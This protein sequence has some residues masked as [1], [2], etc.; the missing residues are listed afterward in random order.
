[1]PNKVNMIKIKVDNLINIVQEIKS[2]HDKS[3]LEIRK[4][5]D[6]K[7]HQNSKKLSEKQIAKQQK[8][9][10]KVDNQLSKL[11][12]L[13]SNFAATTRAYEYFKKDSE[14]FIEYIS[15]KEDADVNDIFV[16]HLYT[17]YKDNYAAILQLIMMCANR[18]LSINTNIYKLVTEKPKLNTFNNEYNVTIK[19]VDDI[20]LLYNYDMKS[21]TR[22]E[23]YIFNCY[24]RNIQSTG[25]MYL[26]LHPICHGDNIYFDDNRYAIIDNVCRDI[27]RKY[28]NSYSSHSNSQPNLPNIEKKIIEDTINV[29]LKKNKLVPYPEDDRFLTLSRYHRMELFVIKKL[30]ELYNDRSNL[31]LGL[32]EEYNLDKDQE[33]FLDIMG[34][35]KLSIL[36]GYPGTGK[37]HVISEI[38][39]NIRTRYKVII[40]APTGIAVCNINNRLSVYTSINE[41]IQQVK[42]NKT[43]IIGNTLSDKEKM[44]RYTIKPLTIHR[45]INKINNTR[46]KKKDDI[47]EYMGDVP[48]NTSG[49]DLS[50]I[51]GYIN[52]NII[53]CMANGI[54]LK[55][56]Q[57]TL[58]EF[59]CEDNELIIII[60]ECSMVNLDVTYG[61]FKALDNHVYGDNYHL[62]LVG[63][64]NQLPPIGIGNFFA[65]ILES[66]K[67]GVG[68]KGVQTGG[69]VQMGCHLHLTKIHRITDSTN[70]S[71]NK[72]KMVSKNLINGILPPKGEYSDSFYYNP[73][74]F[75]DIDELFSDLEEYLPDDMYRGSDLKDILILCATNYTRRILNSKIQSKIYREDGS[76]FRYNQVNFHMDEKIIQLE[77]N[78]DK[79]VFNGE[80]GY[81]KQ[82]KVDSAEKLGKKFI[83]IDFSS[84]KSQIKLREYYKNFSQFDIGYVLTTHKS[85]GIE[86]DTVIII[87]ENFY[88][89]NR[90]LI[91]TAITRAKKKVIMLIYDTSKSSDSY[92]LNMLDNKMLAKVEIGKTIMKLVNCP[93]C[94]GLV[95][96]DEI[97]NLKM[98]KQCFL[99]KN[100]KDTNDKEYDYDLKLKKW[101]VSNK[102]IKCGKCN[103]SKWC[104]DLYPEN[105]DEHKEMLSYSG[106]LAASVRTS[107]PGAS[108]GTGL[109]CLSCYC[110]KYK[111]KRKCYKCTDKMEHVNYGYQTFKGA[112]MCSGCYGSKPYNWFTKGKIKCKECMYMSWVDIKE[113]KTNKK[114]HGK[115]YWC[116]KK[117]ENNSQ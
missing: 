64:Q 47:Q 4:L 84:R 17:K 102:K 34:N 56:I 26:L 52:R 33:Q 72:I 101:V 46:L 114:L 94:E 96:Y 90:N 69:E 19:E 1:M 37:S 89:L 78:Y 115:C 10:T 29:M 2:Q 41:I 20:A 113:Y 55:S 8:D 93:E 111:V 9:T 18:K 42:E 13:D 85:Q 3:R 48:T 11:R 104:F 74:R 67:Y 36:T 110:K 38:V 83:T 30:N 105:P 106:A 107:D 15:N 58:D 45:L 108:V 99:E 109:V 82:N 103:K 88:H 97:D 12:K 35:R 66:N 62:V 25:N 117:D 116:R 59:T 22:I 100:N 81:V 14:F 24:K 77:N 43:G 68:H 39:K 112:P 40:A 49:I 32:P 21:S 87:L 50:E 7:N 27:N 57:E 76:S 44:S 5:E 61:L 73:K 79:E 23:A 71:D 95:N 63:D 91:Y 16:T 92:R 80:I 65:S 98:C 86:A 54:D 28:T 51:T 75:T 53:A 6:I 70:Q 31:H 60:D